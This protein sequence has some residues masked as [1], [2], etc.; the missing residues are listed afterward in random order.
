MKNTLLATVAVLC[1]TA[2][3]PTAAQAAEPS[4]LGIP[5][6]TAAD[7]V[8]TCV[9]D[10]STLVRS[11]DGAPIDVNVVLPPA[12]ASGPDGGYPMLGV[13][14][15]WGGSK[16]SPSG[17]AAGRKITDWAKAGVAVF[18]MSDRGWGDSCGQTSQTRVNPA[19]AQD[20][21]LVGYN[22]LLDT[23]YEVRD[24]QTIIGRIAD[25]E[26]TPGTP[27]ID[28]R[29]VGATGGSYGGGMSMALAA[30]KDRIMLPNGG[31]EQWV[32]PAGKPLSIAAAAPEIPWT[33]LAY[34]LVPTGRT[35]D[36]ANGPSYGDR[37]GVMKATF[38]TGLFATG[39]L[40]SQYA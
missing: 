16:A 2:L 15:G 21:L 31:Y 39:I 10:T 8:R 11:F 17:S 12:P 20:C 30:L 33:D 4:V 32:S 37:V 28:P 9:G 38:V 27:L 34:S 26:L 19:T 36:Y 22:H 24:A 40:G 6:T 1:G 18:S 7:G 25:V 35:L 23:R 3:A 14:H 5:C 13:Y 29:R